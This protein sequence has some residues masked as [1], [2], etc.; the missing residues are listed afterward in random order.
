VNRSS[1]SVVIPFRGDEAGA[2][3]LR[4]ALNR[5]ELGAGDQLIVS[6]NTEEGVAGPVLAPVANVVRATGE[7][8][9]YHARNRG[10]AAAQGD[11]I[12]FIDADT[13]PAPDL[14][15]RY[16]ARPV[17]DD[18]GLLAGAITALAEQQSL[19][20]RYTRARGFYDGERGLG[21]NG[22]EE[23]GAAPTGNLMIRR[24][25]FEALGGFA[26]GIRSAGDFDLC[27][28]AQAAGWRLLRRPEASVEHRHRE[29]LGSFL[30]ML[31]R[32][33]A[34]ASWM[35]RRYPGAVPR[36]RLLP[37]LAT[38]GRDIVRNV[39]ERNPREALYR[40]IDALGL[41]AYNFGYRRSN[42][43]HPG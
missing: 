11:W 6:D 42:A 4:A 39:L 28:R 41:V 19:L 34:G 12:L 7:A 32:Y 29:D 26:E 16:F 33:G 21:A 2:A 8:S 15:D 1:V 40:S 18:C 27:W 23:G 22:S 14:I 43:A 5:L 3:A 9:S 36:W 25:A 31:A 10:A 30:S 17:P 20:A 24:A 13:V 38:S 35:G 37:G